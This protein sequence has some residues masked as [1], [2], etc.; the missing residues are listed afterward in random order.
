MAAL[1][2]DQQYPCVFELALLEWERYGDDTE[3]ADSK[4]T[5]L[6]EPFTLWVKY[7]MGLKIGDKVL[8]ESNGVTTLVFEDIRRLI[9]ELLALAGGNK[10][11][12]GFDPIEPDFGLS[13]R[14]L[15]ESDATVMISS[16]AEIRAEVPT[17]AVNRSTELVGVF[18]VSVWIDYPNQVDRFYGGYGPGLYFFVEPTDIIRFAGE[19]QSE[20]DGL[21][22]YFAGRK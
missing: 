4:T 9:S 11:R 21:G 22:S 20:L 10:D 18:D 1:T 7:R 3:A 14:H 12:M 16:A 8:Y 13:I 17:G 15:T 5:G 6:G 2:H 19:L